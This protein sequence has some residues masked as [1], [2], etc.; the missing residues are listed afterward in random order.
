MIIVIDRI[1][2]PETLT[3]IDS[4]V[5]HSYY[6]KGEE[7]ANSIVA[8]RLMNTAANYFDFS[9]QVGYDIWFHRNGMPGWHQ[10]RDEATFL[11]TGQSHFPICSIVF[12]PHIKDLVG[13]ELVFDNNM[14]IIP[15]TNRLVIFG[16]GLEHK[17][18]PIESGERVSMNINSWIY[19]IDVA[20]NAN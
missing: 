4:N 1:F 12:Y 6:N 17:V 14:R 8:N 2:F 13:G 18:T 5:Y 7:H 3:G 10:D 11:K 15:K 19:P 9:R 20:T 16:P